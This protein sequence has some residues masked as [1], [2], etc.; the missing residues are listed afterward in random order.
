MGRNRS[1]KYKKRDELQCRL[2]HLGK[3]TEEWADV[4][5]VKAFVGNE[6]VSYEVKLQDTEWNRR[7]RNYFRLKEIPLIP[8]GAVGK[9]REENLRLPAKSKRRKPAEPKP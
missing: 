2:I 5:V 8:V 1:M 7:M 6:G 9:I 3:W 4:V